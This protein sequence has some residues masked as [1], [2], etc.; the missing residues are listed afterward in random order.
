MPSSLF[1]AAVSLDDW[2]GEGG[3]YHTP[4]PPWCTCVPSHT[5][6]LP[7]WSGASP[8][9]QTRLWVYSA[10]RHA[11]CTFG[12]SYQFAAMQLLGWTSALSSCACPG[13]WLS[14]SAGVCGM[15]PREVNGCG[16]HRSAS[17]MCT[18]TSCGHGD[19]CLSIPRHSSPFLLSFP[20]KR[21]MWVPCSTNC[22]SP[23]S[24]TLFLLSTGC[25]FPI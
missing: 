3:K 18:V 14:P 25:R 17:L 13:T 9:S 16:V 10:W 21:S 4:A 20:P 24:Q 7:A 8:S 2:W 6:S 23:L 5:C 15:M 22:L 12:Q 1:S 11:G 19:P